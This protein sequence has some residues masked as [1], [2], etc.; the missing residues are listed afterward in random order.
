M[1]PDDGSA[2]D[3]LGKLEA[4]MAMSQ[5]AVED[6]DVA[7]GSDPAKAAVIKRLAA[8][9]LK[10]PAAAA[11]AK[12]PAAECGLDIEAWAKENLCK[13]MMVRLMLS[14]RSLQ[15]AGG[16]LKSSVVGFRVVFFVHLTFLLDC[17]ANMHSCLRVGIFLV[18]S[19]H[20]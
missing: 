18:S 2:A 16:T 11:I 6:I 15:R 10:R 1:D 3:E 20:R 7:S 17:A 19:T 12:R 9:A 8:E 5:E 4:D 13:T 14:S